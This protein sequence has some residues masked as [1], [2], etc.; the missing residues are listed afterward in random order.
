MPGA[1]DCINPCTQQMYGPSCID[2]AWTC[3]DPDMSACGDCGPPVG[4]M[5]CVDPCNDG[6]YFPVCEDG[7]W[8]CDRGMVCGGCEAEWSM[9]WGNDGWDQ[10]EAVALGPG[11]SVA[12]GASFFGSLTFGAAEVTS[13]GDA[14]VLLL[15]LDE[16]GQPLWARSFG[17]LE[18]DDIAGLAVDGE[19][20]VVVAI[21][22]S[23]VVDFGFGS[24]DSTAG[25]TALLKLG[26]DGALLWGQQLAFEVFIDAEGL[27]ANAGGTIVLAGS[28][29]GTLHFAGA[30][31]Q[32]TGDHGIFVAEL[33]SDG[34]HLWSHCFGGPSYEYVRD[35]AI[36]P[37]GGVLLTGDFRE[38]LPLSTVTLTSAGDYD[39]FVASFDDAGELRFAHALGGPGKDLGASI[40]PDGSDGV[41][42]VGA[43]TGT[44]DL[45]GNSLTATNEWDA[46]L[47]RF[48]AT[49]ELNVAQAII[50]LSDSYDLW[51]VA[52]TPAGE[53]LIAGQFTGSTNGTLETVYS[54]G[55]SDIVIAKFNAAGE[56]I[57]GCSF[58][59]YN[60]DDVADAAM[61]PDGRFAIVGRQWSGPEFNLGDG[62]HEHTTDGDS[63]VGV[64]P[65]EM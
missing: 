9:G 36:Y 53:I 43:F 8:I 10:A 3:A 38:S 52:A 51:D 6:F 20:N 27:A 30:D 4:S 12:V 19:G 21:E 39:G 13:A 62:P 5:D 42:V 56:H 23:G 26:S 1:I 32:C 14:D 55:S 2:G 37:S 18:R 41:V 17:G 45:G 54:K 44:A 35:V 16:S 11:G 24:I 64:F 31:L 34:D 29:L 40:A 46:F 28:P 22:F 33:D 7:S 25:R 57:A 65:G 63:F 15:K 47:V 49:G 48:S 60:S 61:A 50:G 59:G 58:G